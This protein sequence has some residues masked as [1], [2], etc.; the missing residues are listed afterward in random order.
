[1]GGVPLESRKVVR[2]SFGPAPFEL[3][4]NTGYSTED[5]RRF[6]VRGLRA[7]GARGPKTFV[8]VAA[9]QRS[10][11]CAEV[12]TSKCAAGEETDVVIALASPHKFSLRR[13]ARLF[14]HEVTHTLGYQHEEMTEEILYSLGPVPD[15]AKG[16]KIRY[17]G[18]APLLNPPKPSSGLAGR[19]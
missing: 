19:E 4:N 15:W 11:G 8:F 5:L 2:G 18:R 17:L 1:M 12:G 13:L 14:E 3:V 10:R 6:C 9:P 16:A 7:L